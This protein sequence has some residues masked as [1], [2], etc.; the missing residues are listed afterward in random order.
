MADIRSI[1]G[2]HGKSYL[3]RYGPNMLPSHRR[4]IND[5]IQCRT[6]AMGGHVESCTHCDHVNYVYHSCGSRSCPRCRKKVAEEWVEKRG[7]E[8]LPVPYFHVVFT[9]PQELRDIIRSNQKTLLSVQMKAAGNSLLKLCEDDKYVGG[10]VGLLSVLHTWTSAMIYHPHVHCLIP[11]GG[12][13]KS[14]QRWTTSRSTFLV[15]VKALSVIYR[16]KFRDM[17]QASAPELNIPASVW[18]KDWVVYCKPVLQGP[19]K[20]LQYLGRYVQR[21]AISDSRII[22]VENGIVHFRYKETAKQKNKWQRKWQTMD[23]PVFEFMRRFLQHVL[24]SGFHKVRYYGLLSPANRKLLHQMQMLLADPVTEADLLDLEKEIT[25]T[26]IEDEK[27]C[28][29]CNKGTMKVLGRLPKMY[30]SMTRAPPVTML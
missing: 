28:R 12:Y 5:I 19:R 24:P 25:A 13:D 10:K 18:Q 11:G 2:Q 14:R 29:C 8:L 20:V 30:P 9:V 17:V 1:F 22:G 21:S 27:I 7:R 26:L 4:A 6:W 16:A 3:T 15:P 23:L